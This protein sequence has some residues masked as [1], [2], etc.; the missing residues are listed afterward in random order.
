MIR[1]LLFFTIIAFSFSYDLQKTQADTHDACIETNVVWRFPGTVAQPGIT[2]TEISAFLGGTARFGLTQHID[3]CSDF[4]TEPDCD[5][6][7]EL[8]PLLFPELAVEGAV[9][10][11]DP[12]Q[13]PKTNRVLYRLRTLNSSD[14][15]LLTAN[16]AGG[17]FGQYTNTTSNNSAEITIRGILIR[18]D[19]PNEPPLFLT[20]GKSGATIFSSQGTLAINLEYF[21]T[22]CVTFSVSDQDGQPI[23]LNGATFADL[24]L[25]P[26]S[27]LSTVEAVLAQSPEFDFLAI[28]D[29]PNQGDCAVVLG[30]NRSIPLPDKEDFALNMQ[31]KSGP[32]EQ[33]LDIDGDGRLSRHD[34]ACFN[35]ELVHSALLQEPVFNNS[36]NVLPNRDNLDL[37]GDGDLD[38]DDVTLYETL[39]LDFGSGLFGDIDNPIAMKRNADDLAMFPDVPLPIF[40]GQVAS[41]G[42]FLYTKV[43]DDDLDGDI[44]C[45]DYQ[46]FLNALYADLGNTSDE[47]SCSIG[48]F[49][50]NAILGS[51]DRTIDNLRV[52][53]KRDG[54]VNSTDW[55]FVFGTWGLT[56]LPANYVLPQ[57]TGCAVTG[58]D[59]EP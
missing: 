52:D 9:E 34:V 7:I 18:D 4:C 17:G 51:W 25:S 23:T 59:C 22:G 57:N 8:Q 46:A 15:T 11:F 48:T 29:S 43:F 32:D 27:Q 1:F 42:Q 41:S 19:N 50:Q 5:I 21:I 44:D 36:D 38:S 33:A 3:T 39:V 20:T 14:G 54:I 30:I 45:E 13:T 24:G 49:D 37:D 47:P 58:P 6:Q 26:F 35:A 53:L 28:V 56:G 16:A 12:V 2:Q 40:M 10:V 31:L 55:V